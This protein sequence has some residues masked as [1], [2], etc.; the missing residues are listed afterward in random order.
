MATDPREHL[1]DIRRQ[2]TRQAD[3]YVRMQQTRDEASLRVLVTLTGVKPG[4]RVLDVA[5]GPGFLT[6][7][8]AGVC[9]E[10]V[11][12]D[13]TEEFVARA[14]KEARR[15]GIENARFEAGDA[16]ALSFESES[17][18]VVS[19]RAAFH[20][21]ARPERVLSEMHRV[22]KRGGRV[23]IAD[24][25]AS[26]D[27]ARAEVHNRIERLC[28]PTHVRALAASEFEAMFEAAGLRVVLNPTSKLEYHVDEWIDH[29]G[30][31]DF[32]VGHERSTDSF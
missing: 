29:G 3:A 15:R 28:D 31:Y 12:I 14:G 16:D 10:A 26:E 1:D 27:P 20:H 5:C 32:V 24:M 23:L 19:C 4:H 18:D 8:F 2:F 11:G 21:F 25:L 22:V 7:E 30:P 13:A 17:F 9:A 6:L